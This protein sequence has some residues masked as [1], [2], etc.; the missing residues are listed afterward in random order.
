M[1]NDGHNCW[2]EFGSQA[3]VNENRDRQEMQ[4]DLF[5]VQ[6]PDTFR[7]SICLERTRPAVGPDACPTGKPGGRVAV[8]SSESD[9]PRAAE[10]KGGIWGTRSPNETAR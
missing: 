10:R 3:V 5:I 2:A 7:W 9:A 1:K 6:S 8:D 4:A